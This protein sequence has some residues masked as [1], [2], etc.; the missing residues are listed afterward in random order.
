M[1]AS[2]VVAKPNAPTVARRA[3]KQLG[4]GARKVAEAIATPLVPEDFLDLIDPLRSGADLRGRVVA[5]R[6]E[7]EGAHR[8]PQPPRGHHPV[9]ID[10]GEEREGGEPQDGCT[11][12]DDDG[13]QE[14][15]R[16]HDEPPTVARHSSQ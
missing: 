4:R 7:G 11:R 8:Q 13:I 14:Q 15:A 10:A 6:R 12:H 16:E 1:T 9:G 3:L 2:G 5:V